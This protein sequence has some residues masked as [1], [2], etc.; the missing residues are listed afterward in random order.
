M[1]K[2]D[3]LHIYLMF[4]TYVIKLKDLNQLNFLYRNRFNDCIYIH[5]QCKNFFIKKFCF[6]AKQ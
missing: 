2:F 3:I 4:C 5:T 1:Y 6:L